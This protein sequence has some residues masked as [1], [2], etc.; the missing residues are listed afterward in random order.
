MDICTCKQLNVNWENKTYYFQHDRVRY[1]ELGIIINGSHIC[2][3]C[4]H[5]DKLAAII[6]FKMSQWVW[7]W[8]NTGKI[9]CY[10]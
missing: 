7:V 5:C 9:K 1:K 2:Y 4:G 10:E 6:L 3:L 8:T